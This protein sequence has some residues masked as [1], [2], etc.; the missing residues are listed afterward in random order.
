M[1]VSASGAGAFSDVDLGKLLAGKVA[2]ANPFIGD[3]DEGFSG[4]ASP[5]DLETMF[6]LIYLYGTQARR[7]TAAFAALQ[8]RLMTF[9]QNR[10]QVPEAVFSDTLLLT[11]AQYHPRVRPLSPAVIKGANLD[12]ALDFYRDRFRDF[13]DFTFYFVGNLDTAALRPLVETWLGGLPSAGRQETWRDLGIRPPTGVIRKIVHRGL[14]P[15]ARTQLVFTGLFE[16]STRNRHVLR[17]MGEALQIRLREVLRED[18]G[19][20]YGVGVGAS[21]QVIPDT[22]YQVTIGF[23]SD[24]A[25]LEE[26][27]QAVFAEVRAFQSAGP[28]DSTVQKVK[29]AQ[30]RTR[31]TSLRENNYWLNQLLVSDRWGLDPRN[32]LKYEEMIDRL[33]AADIRDA[34]Q[35]YIRFDNYVQVTLMPERPNP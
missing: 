13:G 30:R 2:R 19:G 6:Q 15:K 8:T 34:A 28:A 31:E 24:P 22:S 11:I 14:E 3:E 12:V 26:L 5:K 20:V 25:R 17:S 35:R 29:E 33:T 9:A 4:S 10:G 7:D 21:S 32:L 23:G 16:E 18:M 1:V 27:V